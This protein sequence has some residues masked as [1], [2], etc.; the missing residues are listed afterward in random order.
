MH[1]DQLCY[2]KHRATHLLHVQ[3][4][5]YC[6]NY[7]S[8]SYHDRL[9]CATLKGNENGPEKSLRSVLTNA[10]KNNLEVKVSLIAHD[11]RAPCNEIQIMC[12]ACACIYINNYAWLCI[13]MICAVWDSLP[14]VKLTEMLGI[15]PAEFTSLNVFDS[16]Y[17]N[18]L[19]AACC[20]LYTS[21]V[22]WARLRLCWLSVRGS[23][24]HGDG[25][26]S[27]AETFHE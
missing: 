18:A 20:C 11:L 1:E 13:N 10:Y 16:P 26:R 2:A 21:V 22:L 25:W 14:V 3:C 12:N 5:Q 23:Q 9:H 6:L 24:L 17:A 7:W 19:A 15:Y 27:T 4:I 8:S